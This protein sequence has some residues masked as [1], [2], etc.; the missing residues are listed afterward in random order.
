MRTPRVPFS[1]Y[2]RMDTLRFGSSPPPPSDPT[3][4]WDKREDSLVGGEYR[5]LRRIGKGSGGAVYEARHELSGQQVAVKIL[6]DRLTGSDTQRRRFD[7]EARTAAVVVHP[8][9]VRLYDAGTDEDGTAWQVFEL[10]EGRDL[11]S[12][13]EERTLSVNEAVWLAGELLEALEAVH[14]RGFVHRDI[15]PENV[16][17]ATAAGNRSAPFHV[18]LLDFGIAKPLVPSAST[19]W[20]TDEGVMLGTPHFMAPEQIAGDK[21]IAPTTDLWATGAV[22]FTALTGRPPFDDKQLSKLLVRI[23]REPAPSILPLRPDVPEALASIIARALRNHPAHR[24]PSASAMLAALDD[25]LPQTLA[26]A[27]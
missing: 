6:H 25:A 21:P 8:N 13:I 9:I 19:P 7:R 26:P 27:R 2:A 22:L 10:L 1:G 14:A 18:K 15:K 24:F 16:F 20:V 12:L 3:R 5:L 4:R 23:A 17:L 11:A